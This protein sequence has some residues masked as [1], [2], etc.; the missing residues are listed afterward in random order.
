MSIS[1]SIDKNFF[2]N[3]SSKMAYVLGF[4]AADGTIT[5]NPRGSNYFVLQIK[6][7]K[8]L[9]NIREVM[10]SAHKISKRIHKKDD[11]VFYRLQIGSKEMCGDLGKLGFSRNKTKR[12]ALPNIPNE[13]FNDFT[14]G[15]F[16][17]DGNVW[18]GTIHKDRKKKTLSIHTAFTS[19][20]KSFLIDLQSKLR[21]YGMSGGSI[22]C[23]SS[24]FCLK[25]SVKDSIALY[26]LMYRDNEKK[27][28]LKR[29]KQVF[30]NF[31]KKRNYA[32]VV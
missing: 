8:L 28:F 19:C 14:R 31:I 27:L 29:K 32:A 5:I 10:A 2:K 21:R 15:Y 20:S 1:K 23:K 6:D 16:D 17:G 13:F 30:E 25:Y 7:K 26:G 24:A 3:W 9:E 4:F 22:Y 12:L 18:T 11:S